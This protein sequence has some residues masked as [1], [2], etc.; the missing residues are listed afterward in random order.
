MPI[1]GLSITEEMHSRNTSTYDDFR[2]GGSRPLLGYTGY[3]PK[4][5][6]DPQ[7][8]S[9]ILKI[10][11]YT[12][13]VKGSREIHGKPIIPNELEQ[14]ANSESKSALDE[15]RRSSRMDLPFDQ[16][17]TKVIPEEKPEEMD[18]DVDLQERYLH[19][20]EALF[21]RGQTPQMLLRTL[22][23]KVSER[24]TDYSMELRK[25]RNLFDAFDK[26]GKGSLDVPSFRKCL[27]H[28]GCHLDEVQSLALFSFFDDNNDGTVDWKELADQVI[29]YNP[30]GGK[31]VP[32]Q[33]TATMFTEDWNSLGQK[34]DIFH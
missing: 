27:E 16:R 1:K 23:G 30:G 7:I 34:K 18:I 5:S 3:I 28:I 12:G 25:V 20:M 6:T 14:Q 15:M 33:I 26:S 31:L 8:P 32:K 11:G 21:R 19:A 24:V 2:R 9:K 29:M 22:Q 4:A 10:R 17:R 13:H